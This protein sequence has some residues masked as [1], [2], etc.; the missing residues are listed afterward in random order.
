MP[1]LLASPHEEPFIA[2]TLTLP[3]FISGLTRSAV[4]LP[5]QGILLQIFSK[6]LSDRPTVFIEIIQRIGCEREVC[7]PD[8]PDVVADHGFR[9]PDSLLA[10]F[11]VHSCATALRCTAGGLWTRENIITCTCERNLIMLA[12]LQ[13]TRCRA[14]T[15]GRAWSR[16]AAAAAL[17][18]ATSRRFSSPLRWGF[19]SN[20]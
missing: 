12:N 19:V 17:A 7:A 3:S 15:A 9:C 13:L 1:C 14:L 5:L 2:F 10:N 18:R 20:L 4:L 16:R 6:P 8:L 11:V